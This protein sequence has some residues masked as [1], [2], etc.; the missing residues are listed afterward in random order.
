MEENKKGECC[1][2]HSCCGGVKKLLVGLLI[3]AFIFAAGM[4]YAKANCSMGGKIC[5]ISGMPMAR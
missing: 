2:S 4:W 5:P 1:S 3:G